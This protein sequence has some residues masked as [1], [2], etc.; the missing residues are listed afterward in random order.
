MIPAPVLEITAFIKSLARLR[1]AMAWRSLYEREKKP[2]IAVLL[3]HP[4]GM[5]CR[6]RGAYE[7]KAFH[8]KNT[9]KKSRAKAA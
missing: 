1:F 9:K 5:F 2:A 4:R 3:I 6:F 7:A 8:A